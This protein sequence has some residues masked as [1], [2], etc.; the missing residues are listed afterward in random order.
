MA[1]RKAEPQYGGKSRDAGTSPELVTPGGFW[2]EV[3]VDDS[4]DE[5]SAGV[6]LLHNPASKTAGLDRKVFEGGSGGQ[7]PD[8]SHANTE[9]SSD[10]E[11]L[12]IGFNEAATQ[13]ER[14][15]EEEI[16]D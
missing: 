12:V 9:K 3:E 7:T 5:V 14:A 8:T 16:S 6:S 15:D 4:G 11:E 13:G 10:C 2:D 1:F